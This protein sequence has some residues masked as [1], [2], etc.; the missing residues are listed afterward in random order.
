MAIRVVE[1]V[2]GKAHLNWLGLFVL[3]VGLLAACSLIPAAGMLVA[4]GNWKLAGTALAVGF[5]IACCSLPMLVIQQIRLPIEKLPIR[6]KQ[7]IALSDV[8]SEQ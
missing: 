3:F 6:V 1:N 5:S 7:T 2:Q 8:N 4:F